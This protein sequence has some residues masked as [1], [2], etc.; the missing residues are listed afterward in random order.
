MP[1]A[2][3]KRSQFSE[4]KRKQVRIG[5]D[6]RV[7][8]LCRFPLARIRESGSAEVALASGLVSTN[9]LK[10]LISSAVEKG[11][12]WKRSMMLHLRGTILIPPFPGSN[13]GIPANLVID[14]A[15]IDMRAARTRR[16]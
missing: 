12:M 8:F 14:G 3:I 6:L 7:D 1:W 2:A 9:S 11:T 13:P 5:C 10:R 15:R 4:L 16:S